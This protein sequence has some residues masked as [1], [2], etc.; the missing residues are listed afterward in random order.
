MRLVTY[1]PP[2]APQEG[3]SFALDGHGRG[4]GLVDAYGEVAVVDLER[5]AA[6]TG[7]RLP[8]RL[9]DLIV[10]GPDA[11]DVAR[12]VLGQARSGVLPT[13]YGGEEHTLPLDLV[14]LLAPVPAPPMVRDFYAFEDH[15]RRG[16]AKRGAD[17][18]DEWYAL[19]AFYKQNHRA[20]RG[21]D[22]ELPWPAF[23][24]ELDYEL[25]IAMVVGV[26]GRDIPEDHAGEHIFGFTI[27]NDVSARDLQRTEM[28]MRLGPAK[29]KDFATVLGPVLVTRDELDPLDLR[30]VA[31]L[32]G[33]VVTDSRTSDMRWTFEQMLAY[34]SIDEDVFPGDVFGSG[35]VAGGC[36]LEHGRMLAPGDV[37]ELDVPGIG[38]LRNRVGQ[39]RPKVTLPRP[40]AE[41]G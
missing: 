39:P 35:T 13:G 24:D 30:P 31:R 38:V 18:P 3:T 2:D 14:R 32:N 19:P 22:E 9:L 6:A 34:V 5:A 11:W 29:S 33:E 15:V 25:E 36:G 4:A 20:I 10:A 26:G 1:L 17:I 40:R 12:D 23:T 7:R 41:L 37:L 8:R 21:P 27:L 16:F 28:A